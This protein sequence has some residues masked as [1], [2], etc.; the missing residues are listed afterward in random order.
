MPNWGLMIAATVV[1]T[2]ALAEWPRQS[3][4]T[5]RSKKRVP[6]ESTWPQTALSN[7]ETGFRT[8]KAAPTSAPARGAPSSRAMDQTSQP[9]PTSA[10][11]G[12][13]LMRSPIPPIACPTRPTSQRT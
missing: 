13:S 2:V 9:M 8:K 3:S 4:R 7:Q 1:R 11:I 5:A 10:R 12:G 6:K